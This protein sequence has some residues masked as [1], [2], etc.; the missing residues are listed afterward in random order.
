MADKEPMEELKD[1]FKSMSAELAEILGVESEEAKARHKKPD[2][3]SGMSKEL[4]ETLKKVS[5][6]ID[7]ENAE[8][9]L[10]KALAGIQTD[11]ITFRDVMEKALDRIAVLEEGTA[12]KKSLDGQDGDKDALLE[13]AKETAAKDGKGI[14]GPVMG[15]LL[16]HGKV[17][18]T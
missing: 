15:S 10:V 4:A 9:P 18:L 11:L 6:T 13:K 5:E 1:C 8:S 3:E 17:T 2:E 12:T 7:L 16:K 14:W